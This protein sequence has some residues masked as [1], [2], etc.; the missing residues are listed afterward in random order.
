LEGGY[1]YIRAL[2]DEFLLKSVV[3]KFIS[4]EISRAEISALLTGVRSVCQTSV[5]RLKEC[6]KGVPTLNKGKSALQSMYVL[7]NIAITSISPRRILT[8]HF[9]FN[10]SDEKCNYRIRNYYSLQEHIFLVHACTKHNLTKR[11]RG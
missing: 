10:N 3:F 9:T 1:S 8:D 5:K 2:H 6:Q 7:P 11:H 4:K